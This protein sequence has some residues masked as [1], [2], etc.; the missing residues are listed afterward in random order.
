MVYS[1]SDFIWTGT[2]QTKSKYLALAVLRVILQK[3]ILFTLLESSTTDQNIISRRSEVHT[4]A[5]KCKSF[6][7]ILKALQASKLIIVSCSEGAQS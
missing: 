5:G 3:S 2:Q 4:K 6:I 1:F 7:I